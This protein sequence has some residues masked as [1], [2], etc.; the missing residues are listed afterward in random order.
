MKFY[1]LVAF[2]FMLPTAF[3]EECPSFLNVRVDFET[4]TLPTAVDPQFE[5]LSGTTLNLEFEREAGFSDCRMIEKVKGEMTESVAKRHYLTLETNRN[6]VRLSVEGFNADQSIYSVRAKREIG[7]SY[8][9]VYSALLYDASG[10]GRSRLGS[11]LITVF[12]TE[13]P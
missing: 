1:A 10:P 3:A 7:M 9:G 12:G 2:L 11:A 5:A 4:F 13:S 8:L 6:E